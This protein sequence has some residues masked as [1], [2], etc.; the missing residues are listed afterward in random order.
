MASLVADASCA[1]VVSSGRHDDGSLSAQERRMSVASP[2][3]AALNAQAQP[4]AASEIPDSHALRAETAPFRAPHLPTSVGQIASSFLLYL[5]LYA[6]MHAS[7]VLPYWVTL[8]LALPTAGFVVRIFIIQHDCGHGSLFRSRRINDSVG[9]LC[10]LITLTP[11]SMWRRQHAGHH[12]RWNN[13]DRRLSGSDIYSTCLTLAEFQCLSPGRRFVYRASRHPVVANLLLPPLVF[14]LLYRVPFDAPRSWRHERAAVYATNLALLAVFAG[15]GFA[16]GL[17]RELLVQLPVTA[18]ASIIGVW[19]FSVQH[20]FEGV[21]WARQ[22]DWNVLDASLRSC[23]YLKLPRILR[24]F[25]GNIGFHHVHHLDPKVPNY[26][27]AECHRMCPAF[28]ETAIVLTLGGALSSLRYSLW[29][30]T[31]ARL[32]PAPRH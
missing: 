3:H 25:T 24:W 13:L 21:L 18:A 30:E 27:L 19:L 22:S 7:L 4:P 5:V 12:A 16:L 17:R 11:Y 31:R 23:S 2:E 1:A 8:A 9:M 26:R 6:L 29:D 15:L 14:L 32:V 10:S 28:A 20:R